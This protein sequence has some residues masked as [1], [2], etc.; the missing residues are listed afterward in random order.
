MEATNLAAAR[1]VWGVC[2]TGVFAAGLAS[3]N[4]VSYF[5]GAT[6]TLMSSPAD[7]SALGSQSVNFMAQP[8]IVSTSTAV[9]GS[10]SSSPYATVTYGDSGARTYAGSTASSNTSNYATYTYETH[11]PTTAARYTPPNLSYSYS[12]AYSASWTSSSSSRYSSVSYGFGGYSVVANASPS[13]LILITTPSF[14]YGGLSPTIAKYIN[15][16]RRTQIYQNVAS[17]NAGPKIP[18]YAIN[19]STPEPGGVVLV[20]G[21]LGVLYAL[22]RRLAGR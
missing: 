14:N 16:V 5:Y 2:L 4:S 15:D 8:P 6:P 10:D 18:S 19:I 17:L 1:L 13:E 12:P 9:W 11:Q 7:S 21:G 3:A 22:R 20:L